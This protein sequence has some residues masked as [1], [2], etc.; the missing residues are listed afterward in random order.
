MGSIIGP[1]QFETL[2][3]AVDAD[4]GASD[5]NGDGG[6]S[7]F[8]S[9]GGAGVTF[10][11]NGATLPTAF[12]IVLTDANPL[13]SVAFKATDGNGNDLGSLVVTNGFADFSFAGG[14]AEDRFFGITFEGGIKSISISSAGGGMEV[15]HVQYGTAAAAVPVPA[16]VYLLGSALGVMLSTRRRRG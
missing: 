14:T 1:G 3:D 8:T 4:D 13:L 16:A 11:F 10:T 5:G 2:R 6:H 9:N 15:D 12:G 7:W